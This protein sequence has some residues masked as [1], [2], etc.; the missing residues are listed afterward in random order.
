MM[1]YV[2]STDTGGTFVDAVIVDFERYPRCRQA[3][4]DA[5]R[6]RARDSRG[7]RG[8]GAEFRSVALRCALSL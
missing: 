8:G 7:S 3:L 5:K 1:D 4:I 2:I 6:A